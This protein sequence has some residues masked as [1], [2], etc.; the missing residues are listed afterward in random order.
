MERL[1][2][3]VE[4][5]EEQSCGVFIRTTFLVSTL[6]LASWS[7]QCTWLACSLN[8]QC[9]RWQIRY[10]GTQVKKKLQHP[11]RCD[12]ENQSV[13]SLVNI[14]LVFCSVH[15]GT[16]ENLRNLLRNN[17]TTYRLSA[18]ILQWCLRN[19]EEIV[20]IIDLYEPSC[21]NL[22][23]LFAAGE[24]DSLELCSPSFFLHKEKIRLQYKLSFLLSV[25]ADS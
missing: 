24:N 25:L 6:D 23:Q 2:R 7:G 1:F 16:C 19:V 18:F 8:L 4:R 17:E 10:V 14:L 22:Q 9:G 12:L 21:T 5:E 3:T 11:V 20:F 13:K 15:C